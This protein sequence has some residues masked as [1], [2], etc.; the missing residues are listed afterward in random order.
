MLAQ[1]AW[2][3]AR[4]EVQRVASSPR[5]RRPQPAWSR[6]EALDQRVHW[7]DTPG[8]FAGSSRSLVDSPPSD[9][10]RRSAVSAMPQVPCEGARG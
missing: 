9:R 2:G 4:G 1:S 7:L 6:T 8:D 5:R 10:P 3:A